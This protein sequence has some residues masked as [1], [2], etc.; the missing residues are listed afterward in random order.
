MDVPNVSRREYQLVS[1][2]TQ[3]GLYPVF[4]ANSV[5]F[6]ARHLR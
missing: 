5:P 3:S 2:T 6:S 4:A 1:I